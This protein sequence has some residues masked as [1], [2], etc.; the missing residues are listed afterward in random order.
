[1]GVR[2]TR[3]RSTGVEFECLYCIVSVLV[4]AFNNLW[5]TMPNPQCPIT[6]K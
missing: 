2:I 4:S 6:L 1:M 3:H 5:A